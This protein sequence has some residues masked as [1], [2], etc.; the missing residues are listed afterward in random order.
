[1]HHA[2]VPCALLVEDEEVN[3]KIVKRM[4]GDAYEV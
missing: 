3:A 2:Y 4:L 1:V